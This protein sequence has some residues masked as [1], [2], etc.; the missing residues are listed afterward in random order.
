MGLGQPVP[1]LAPEALRQIP[2]SVEKSKEFQALV[3][4]NPDMRWLVGRLLDSEHAYLTAGTV[5]F[6]ISSFPAIGAPENAAELPSN[7]TPEACST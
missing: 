3:R 7:V 1:Q 4:Q 2:G 5:Y 6:D